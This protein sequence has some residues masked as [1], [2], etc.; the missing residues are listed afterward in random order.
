MIDTNSYE[1]GAIRIKLRRDI[2]FRRQTN[3]DVECY[4][5]EDPVGS[6]FYRIGIAEY[7]FVSVLDGQTT[8]AEAVAT[9]AAQ[10]G[11]ASLTETEA[12]AL[13]GWLLRNSLAS[14]PQ[15]STVARLTTQ[16]D[17]ADAARQREWL[18]PIM[19]KLPLGNPSRWVRRITPWT[20][21]IFSLVGLL[22]WAGVFIWGGYLVAT[23]W[24]QMIHTSQVFSTENWFWLGVCWVGLK[25][26][27][28]AAHAIACQRYGGETREA[29]ILW[30]MFVPL[31][32]V[33][34]TAAWRIGSRWQRIAISA[35]GM[36]AELFLAACAAIVWTQCNDPLVR[37]HAINVLLTGAV[38]TLLFNLNPLM[39]FDGYHILSD[40]FELPN[41][42]P[43]GQQ[44]IQYLARR[45]LLGQ[46]A[47]RPAWPEGHALF[48][49]CYGIAALAWRGLTCLSLILGAELLFHG[50]GIVLASLAAAVWFL[51][52]LIKLSRYL[53]QGDPV[54]PPN[55]LWFAAVLALVAISGYAVWFHVPYLER[56]QLPAVV[57]CDPVISV[58]T[59]SS[60]FLRSIAVTSGQLV[61]SG[62]VLAQLENPDLAAR[63]CTLQIEMQQSQLESTRFQRQ[64][65]LAAAQIEQE[66]FAALSQK[67][68]E[69]RE[70][71]EQLTIYAPVA[72]TILSRNLQDQQGCWLPAGG[73][74]CQLGDDSTRT[75]HVLI[76]Q[77]KIQL[78]RDA[79]QTPIRV[80]MWG[81]THDF[82]GRLAD[83]HSRGSTRLRHRELSANS[84]GPLAVRAVSS[85]QTGQS[86][87][88][89]LEPHFAARV[90]AA[91]M[92]LSP[93]WNGETG[94]VELVIS[95]QSIGKHLSASLQ[96]FWMHRGT[97]IR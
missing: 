84:G 54:N 58:R 75:I 30:L 57:D 53:V 94:I 93:L 79:E 45:W 1:L 23:Q 68:V 31:P 12:A 19:L 91:A 40:L 56:L 16:A 69:L 71:S 73:E 77:S 17:E 36:Y 63:I 18:N 95:Q 62:Q 60:G 70:Q 6:Q 28:E 41:L 33:D 14:T 78:V 89:L 9:C 5:I 7:L 48:I 51:L 37:T 86:D 4:L 61:E 72:G 24:R 87:W 34:V 35:A 64:G 2:A 46:H 55:R 38:V 65:R 39:R 74:L 67:L 21:W 90:D 66:N 88:Q 49:R 44:D 29:G 76:P 47:N 42:A 8:I 27:H 26:V 10:S 50:A 11:A 43:H 20:G 25:L 81:R 59:S 52:P 32:Y 15:S 96:E 92:E 22:I 82:P 13:C 3:G 97:I 85:D 83:I 80:H